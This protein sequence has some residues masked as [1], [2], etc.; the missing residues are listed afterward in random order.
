MINLEKAKKALEASEEKAKS[1][2][3]AVT[4]VI[5]DCQ[6]SIIAASRMDGA[7]PISPRFAYTK[8]FTSASLG[9]PSDG[10]AEFAKEGKPYF[11][12]NSIFG[13]EL[14]PIAGGV[15]VTTKGELVGG[16]GVGGSMDVSQDKECA[17]AAANALVG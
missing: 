1:L 12:V 4:T 9:V 13:G 17:Q 8:A 5:V 7:I 15:P 2:G 16:V 14:T 6:G 3:V 11:G 10:L